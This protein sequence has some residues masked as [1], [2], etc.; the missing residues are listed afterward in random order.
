MTCRAVRKISF[1]AYYS[2]SEVA[3]GSQFDNK[4]KKVLNSFNDPLRLLTLKALGFM[5]PV[6]LPV[7]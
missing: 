6:Q 4:I 2:I 7:K 5:L 1:H 3:L